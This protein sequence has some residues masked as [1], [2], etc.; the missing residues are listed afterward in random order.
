M[1]PLWKIALAALVV[2]PPTVHAQLPSLHSSLMLRGSI[3]TSSRVFDNPD[4]PDAVDRDHFDFVDN[5]IGGGLEYRLEFPGQDFFLSLSVEYVSKITTANQSILVDNV[6]H[7]F[8]VEQ[9]VRF[10]PIELGANTSV[11][12]V[13][14]NLTLTMGGG[15]G[16]YYADRV[17]GIAGVRMKSKSL[18]TGYGLHIESGFD[19]RLSEGIQLSCEMRFRDPEVI[20]E[21]EFG[22]DVIT[23]DNYQIPVNNI[24]PKTKINVHGVSFTVGIIFDLGS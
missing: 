21:S 18:P 12:I 13:G 15:F 20:N 8:P 22:T 11:P 4:A 10:V 24:P 2:V 23:V 17:F 9:G 19:Y 14:D 5:L 3:V 1:R 6:V 16:F 7:Q